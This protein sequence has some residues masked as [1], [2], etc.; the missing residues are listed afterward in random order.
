MSVP[1]VFMMIS[2]HAPW[3]ANPIALVI[4]VVVGWGLVYH[5]YDR[6]P[7]VKGF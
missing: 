5:L 4:V 1:L 2:Q 6:A 7:K 3:A